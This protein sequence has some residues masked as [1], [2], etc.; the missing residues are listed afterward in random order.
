LDAA[1]KLSAVTTVADMTMQGGTVK[2]R[3][4]FTCKITLAK[5]Q[6]DRD[7]GVWNLERN[8]RLREAIEKCL[9][10][11]TEV[12]SADPGGML[13]HIRPDYPLIESAMQKPENQ[14]LLKVYVVIY[15]NSLV[16]GVE[17]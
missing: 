3:E 7:G 11:G 15:M 9:A 17:K 12:F 13:Y 2:I 8:K 1:T 5:K 16:V 14:G 10:T 4:L 6:K